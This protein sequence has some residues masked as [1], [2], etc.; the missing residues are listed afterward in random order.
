MLQEKALVLDSLKFLINECGADPTE[1][2]RSDFPIKRYVHKQDADICEY[3][4]NQNRKLKRQQNAQNNKLQA[5]RNS[6]AAATAMT[7]MTEAATI[8]NND[9]EIFPPAA[10]MSPNDPF[11]FPA[12]PVA[13]TTACGYSRVEI[14]T[15]NNNHMFAQQQ[16][17][18]AQFPVMQQQQTIISNM[19]SMGA[20]AMTM[21]SSCMMQSSSAV[22]SNAM[23]SVTTL[24]QQNITTIPQHSAPVSCNV[25]RIP[26]PHQPASSVV[27][28]QNQQPHHVT[29][30]R[31]IQPRPAAT[32][33][34]QQQQI[35]ILPANYQR[36]QVYTTGANT[37]PQQ[38]TSVANMAPAVQSNQPTVMA[39]S[40]QMAQR[41]AQTSPPRPLVIA[42]QQ[43]DTAGN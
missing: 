27:I 5:Q 20:P 7:T 16:Q 9:I 38:M 25:Q 28:P 24:Q 37:M 26:Q 14:P 42:A 36:R 31:P 1:K 32:S 23:D 39:Q 43:P 10:Q 22:H 2:D 13:T 21:A 8:S 40:F 29:Q 19:A 11:L 15:M 17:P 41:M 3:L 4:T 34:Q 33:S 35:P 30:H 12:N 18:Q 6:E